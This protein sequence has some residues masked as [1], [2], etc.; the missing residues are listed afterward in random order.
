MYDSFITVNLAKK[1]HGMCVADVGSL[2]WAYKCL[3]IGSAGHKDYASLLI[4]GWLLVIHSDR[5]VRYRR[6]AGVVL[7]GR[8][9]R[10][11]TGNNARV[12]G[13]WGWADLL[14]KKIDVHYLRHITNDQSGIGF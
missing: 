8:R 12:A 4:G 14:L 6:A 13:R 5:M 10:E 7:G 2:R 3:F 1:G 9:V 11:R